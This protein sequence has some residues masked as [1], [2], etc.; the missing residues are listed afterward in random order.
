MGGDSLKWL[1]N[2][3]MLQE[4]RLSKATIINIVRKGRE[5]EGSEITQRKTTLKEMVDSA[6]DSGPY[7]ILQ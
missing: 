5:A 3:R 1:E 7:F 4:N 6:K 2:E